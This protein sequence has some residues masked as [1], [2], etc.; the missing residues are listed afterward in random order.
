MPTNSGF[1]SSGNGDRLVDPT[2]YPDEITDFLR[3]EEK[4]LTSMASQ[5]E[6]LIEVG[7]MDGRHLGWAIAQQKNYL[8]IDI[9]ERYI[10]QGR[11]KIA[12]LGLPPQ[13]FRMEIY[14]ASKLHETPYQ[15]GWPQDNPS[16]LALFPFNSFGNMDDPTGVISS[17]STAKI[18][19]LIS[20]YLT[21]EDTNKIRLQ[22]YKNCGYENME[23]KTDEMGVRYLSNDGLDT[24][25]YYRDYLIRTFEEHGVSIKPIQFSSVGIAYKG[26]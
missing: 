8:G 10:Q 26:F 9:V 15:E 3:E 19:F 11:Q 18:P 4:L 12:Q 23:C 24:I 17:L 1:Y 22:Y 7:C 13:Q 20:S 25:A 6:M 21:D 16:A 5:F 2:R 14:D